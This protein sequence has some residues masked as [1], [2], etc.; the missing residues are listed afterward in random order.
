MVVMAG[1]RTVRIELVS[2]GRTRLD[3]IMY[4]LLPNSGIEEEPP[5]TWGRVKALFR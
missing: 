1:T 2:G 5:M 4:S 3:Y